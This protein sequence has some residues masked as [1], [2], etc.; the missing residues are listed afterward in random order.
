MWGSEPVY[1]D[2]R[3]VGYT[4]SG[5]YGHTVGGGVGLAYVKDE[6]GVTAEFIQA[7]RYEIFVSGRRVPAKAYLQAPYDP[8]RRRILA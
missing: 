6:G 3:P 1:R 5:S 8:E 4:T 7:G 2:G